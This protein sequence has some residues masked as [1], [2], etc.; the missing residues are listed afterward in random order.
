MHLDDLPGDGEPETG[1]ALGLGVRAVNLM[2]LHEDA[3]LVLGGDGLDETRRVQ[4][5]CDNHHLP[6]GSPFG[7]W[8]KV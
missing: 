1:A 5:Y 6:V 8:T 4:R 3:C 2:E 7:H